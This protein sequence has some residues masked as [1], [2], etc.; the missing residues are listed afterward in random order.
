MLLS[1]RAFLTLGFLVESLRAQQIVNGQIYTSGIAI[2]NAPQPNTPLGG[3]KASPNLYNIHLLTLQD[4]LHVS[5]DVTDNGQLRLPPYPK[6]SPSGIHN[7]TIFLSSYVTG[8]NFTVTNGTATAN[9][10]TTGDIML[11]EAGSTV[12]H[13]NWMW[14]ACLVG[15]GPPANSESDRGLYN[16]CVFKHSCAET[17]L[18]IAATGVYP[19]E[20]PP[21]WHKPIYNL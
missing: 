1:L 18:L 12:K 9:N 16:V 5:L 11:A 6:D 17:V 13:V 4:T 3:G 14:P 21:E 2:V 19:S 10:S 8:W 15:V 20:L 7:I